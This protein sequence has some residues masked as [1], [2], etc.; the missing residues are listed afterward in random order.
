MCVLPLKGFVVDSDGISGIATSPSG[1][2]AG[3]KVVFV[4]L[5]GVHL[6]GDYYGK[7]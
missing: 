4:F 6:H 7:R 1:V 3:R 2:S 5:E